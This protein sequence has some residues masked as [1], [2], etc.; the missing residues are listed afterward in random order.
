MTIKHFGS[1]LLSALAALSITGCG[2]LPITDY[3][4]ITVSIEPLR[5]V[6]QAVTGQT[7]DIETL[8]PAGASP[9]TYQPTP[10]QIANMNNSLA[11]IRVGTL[12]FERTQLDKITENMPH[13]LCIDASR[14]IPPIPHRHLH[15]SHAKTADGDA[16]SDPHTWTSPRNMKMMADNICEALAALDTT[17]TR[18]FVTNFER[19]ASRMDSLDN[20]IRHKLDAAKSRAFL[21]YHPALAYFA[22]DYNLKQF[23]VE[24]DGKEASAER[25]AELIEECKAA[26][27]KVVFVQKEYAGRTARTIADEIGAR[28]VEI[29]P[30]AYDYEQEM[31]KIVTAL[32]L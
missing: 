20:V 23:S 29:N 8:T 17:N 2:S 10:Q 1:I 27:V 3:N 11:Y 12:G 30:L 14:H 5:Y 22:R 19:F 18:L 32:T 16:G 28:I 24:E 4:T 15:P 26:D 9:E 13:L 31:L 25:L 7:F 21:V 6:T